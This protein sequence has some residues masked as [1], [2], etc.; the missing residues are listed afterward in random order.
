MPIISDYHMHSHHSGDSTAPMEDMIL[1]SIEKGL[2]E[3]CFTEH[4][5]MDYP[6]YPDINKDSFTLDIDTY[7]RELS[8]LRA[9]YSD[10]IKV[11]FGI[12]IGMQS[13]ISDDNLRVVSS[14]DFDFVIASQ[15]L[16]DR[17]DPFYPDFWDGYSVRALFDRFFD[18]TLEN[19]KL[20]TD[21]DVLGHL[22]YVSRYVPKGDTTYSYEAF[23]EKIDRILIHLIENGKGLDLN[24]KALSADPEGEPNPS[25]AIIRR[26]KELGGTI[27][28]FGSDAHSPGK[29]ACGFERMSKIAL[30]CGFSEYYTFEKRKPIPHSL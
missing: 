27:I 2:K 4:D 18:E 8:E 17:R 10:K 5:D 7:L 26:F 12:E 9:K 11:R 23:K 21:Y 25:T 28:T 20:F 15:H 30:S 14:N 19:L 24:S 1:S 29:V 3:I 6:I 22:D 16:V 13:Q